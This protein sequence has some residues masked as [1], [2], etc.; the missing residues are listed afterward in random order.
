MLDISCHDVREG[1]A[2]AETHM[3]LH[4]RSDLERA[5]RLRALKPLGCFGA[6]AEQAAT[7]AFLASEDSSFMTGAVPPADGG[8]PTA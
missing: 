4:L 3:N 5:T 2:V 8:W 6:P 7:I 1:L